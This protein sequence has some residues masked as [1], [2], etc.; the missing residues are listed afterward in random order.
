MMMDDVK[1]ANYQAAMVSDRGLARPENQD[2]CF[3]D[4]EKG[5]FIVADGMGG[6]QAGATA[7]KRVVEQLPQLLDGEFGRVFANG[8]PVS[9]V[10]IGQAIR[11][12]AVRLSD[13]VR[14]EG[15]NHIEKRGMG[16]TV[17]L[18]WIREYK[19]YLM[20]LGD[21][22]IYLWRQGW[23]RQLTEDHTVGMMLLKLN[24]ITPAELVDKPIMHRL[25]RCVGMEGD[26]KP[27]VQ[28]LALLPK[29][30]LLLCS[31][32]LTQM[33]SDERLGRILG[34][35]GEPEDLCQKFVDAANASGGLDNIT[36]VVVFVGE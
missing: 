3:M 33:I 12:A 13:Q 6:H 21:S 10:E 31:D 27:E 20:H 26:A 5:L 15:N 29:D 1:K 23:L 32:G 9:D 35:D 17:V 22:R 30:R 14:D 18:S 16:A 7:A 24:Q 4:L 11:R 34:G 8:N 25:S 36:A 28:K 19:L 2:A